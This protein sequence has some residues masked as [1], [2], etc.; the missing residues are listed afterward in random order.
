MMLRAR[1]SEPL[2]RTR[3]LTYVRSSVLTRT[4]GSLQKTSYGQHERI[5]GWIGGPAERPAIIFLQVFEN[6]HTV[7]F[8]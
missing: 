4:M 7:L 1:L 5:P 8:V 2:L 3:Q 6:S